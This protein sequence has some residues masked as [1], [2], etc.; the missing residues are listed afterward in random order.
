M[1]SR[2]SKVGLVRQSF[3]LYDMDGLL[4]EAGAER[5]SEDASKKLAEFL[6]DDAK[7]IL[8]KAG[9]YAKHAGR[10]NIMKKDV[11]LA[12]KHSRE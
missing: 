1:L 9:V 6:E 2:G 12:A 3:S 5:V 10:K 4:R 7:R 11:V 8:F